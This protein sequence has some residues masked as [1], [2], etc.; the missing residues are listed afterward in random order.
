MEELRILTGAHDNISQ[1][2]DADWSVDQDAGQIVFT[3][4]EGVVATCPVQIIGTY[5]TKTG[6]WLWGWDNPSVEPALQKA[7]R[8]VRRYG[9]RH[10]IARLTTRKLKC[11]EDEAWEFAAFACKLCQGQGAYRGP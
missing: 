9:E 1:I 6:T 2:G 7:A 5:D 8:R 3:S 11:S 10:D 4:P